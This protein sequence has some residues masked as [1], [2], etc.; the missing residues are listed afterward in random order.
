MD[1]GRVRDIRGAKESAQFKRL[2]KWQKIDLDRV[3]SEIRKFESLQEVDEHLA[4]HYPT[5]HIC[6]LQQRQEREKLEKYMDTCRWY[7]KDPYKFCLYIQGY[8]IPWLD[9]QRQEKRIE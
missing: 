9:Q 6:L 2:S 1:Q 5:L 4:W 8:F 7:A 3:E